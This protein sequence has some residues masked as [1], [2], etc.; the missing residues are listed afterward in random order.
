MVSKS[1]AEKDVLRFFLVKTTICWLSIYFWTIRIPFLYLLDKHEEKL[2]ERSTPRT[3]TFLRWNTVENEEIATLKIDTW[4]SKEIPR[5]RLKTYHLRGPCY[6][7]SLKKPLC[8]SYMLYISMCF[9]N[10]FSLILRLFSNRKKGPTQIP[11]NPQRKSPTQ[12]PTTCPIFPSMNSLRPSFWRWVALLAKILQ[13]QVSIE[14][15][16]GWLGYIGDDI[17][18]SYIGINF[19][20]HEIR[21]PEP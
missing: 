17:L 11:T 9:Y 13:R 7:V 3:S 20:N 19:I 15:Y 12:A 16:P 2:W 8:P 14:K 1:F 10:C 21:I 6:H 18:P 5:F 4:R